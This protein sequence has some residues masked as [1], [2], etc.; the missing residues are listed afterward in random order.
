MENKLGFDSLDFHLFEKVDFTEFPA[1]RVGPGP[2]RVH[3][4]EKMIFT[5]DRK[6]EEQTA[7]YLS[8]PI[9]CQNATGNLTFTSFLFEDLPDRGY[10]MLYEKPY[11]DCGTVKMNTECHA[12]IPARE[13]PFRIGI[14]A[15]DMA[16]TEGS[17]IMLDN[18]MY[19]ASLC[20]PWRT[21]SSSLPPE[22][23]FNM[24]GSYIEPEGRYALLYIEQDTKLEACAVS[25]MGEE[26]E[27]YAPAI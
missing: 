22:L 9:G 20:K 3:Q 11:V 19:R 26:I 17:F 10:K 18:I 27:C 5:G 12:E 15:Y 6:R 23:L 14:R 25:L 8:S 21:S 24:T 4:G 1:L 7:I 2:T 13:T 16:T